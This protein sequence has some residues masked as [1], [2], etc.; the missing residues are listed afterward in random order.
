MLTNSY[1]T[2]YEAH[3]TFLETKTWFYLPFKF[4]SIGEKLHP[5]SSTTSGTG[6]EHRGLFLTRQVK[7]PF[8]VRG[9]NV[10][11]VVDRQI[12]VPNDRL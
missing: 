8:P 6:K 11:G 3:S 5:N 12:K 2:T 7:P 10:A 4:P 1:I 9:S